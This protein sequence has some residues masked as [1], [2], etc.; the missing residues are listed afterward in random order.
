MFAEIAKFLKRIIDILKVL[1]EVETFI[2]AYVI[3]F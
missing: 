1:V 3:Y 2:R